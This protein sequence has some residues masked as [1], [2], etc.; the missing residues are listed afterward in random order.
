VT[1]GCI[2][3]YP[4]DIL[5]LYP[6]AP[7]GTPVNIIY[8]PIKIGFDQGRVFIEVHEDIYHRIPDPFQLA[9]SR[10]EEK[11]IKSFVNL[12]KMKEALDQKRGVPVEI[13]TNFD[14]GK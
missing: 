7:V 6:M 5:L 2:R 14:H 1:H 9:L 3:L 12:E 13:T 4:E 8:E 11:G 10:L